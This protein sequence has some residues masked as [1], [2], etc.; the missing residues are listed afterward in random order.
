MSEHPQAPIG[1]TVVLCL[2]SKDGGG[3]IN[4]VVIV[5]SCGVFQKYNDKAYLRSKEGASMDLVTGQC[6][7]NR[8]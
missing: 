7:W 1:Q 8:G 4:T 3:R 2:V 6:A 5:A